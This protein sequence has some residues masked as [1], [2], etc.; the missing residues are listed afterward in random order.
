MGVLLV[1]EGAARLWITS[2]N[3]P[4]LIWGRMALNIHGGAQS[5][6]LHLDFLN[7]L[8]EAYVMLNGE[9][10]SVMPEST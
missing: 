1:T 2:T 3:A 9:Q 10:N 5:L 8:I 7:G 4:L 6:N